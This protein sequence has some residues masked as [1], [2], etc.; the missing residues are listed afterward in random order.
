MRWFSRRMAARELLSGNHPARLPRR[1]A[2]RRRRGFEVLEPRLVLAVQPL[3]TEIMANNGSSLLDG[4]GADSDWIEV[5]NPTAATVNLAGWHLTDSAT[6]LDKWTFSSAPQSI[7]D[8]GEYLIVFASSKT[9]ETYI[10]PSGYLHT[11]FALA[12]EGE[13]LALTDAS[14]NI[15]HEFA[16]QFPPQ[17]FDVSY[18]LE[19]NTTTVTLI[20]DSSPVTSLVPTSGVLDA[21]SVGVA[22]AWTV[23]GFD[24][25]TWLASAAGPGVGFDFG[26]DTVI[27]NV[28]NGTVLPTGLVGS[29]LT[30]AD[31]NGTLEGTIFG[32]G[33]P[34]WPS[35]EEPPRALDNTSAT[36]W[37]AFDATGSSYGFRFAGGQQHAVN[38]YTITSAND[39]A[40]RDPYSWTLSG[41]ND[42]VNYTIVDTRS[43][44]TFSTRFQTRLYEFNNSTNYEYYRFDFKTKFGVT[45]LEVDRPSANAIQLA[46]IELFA[47]GPVDFDPLV[48]LDVEA[49]WTTQRTSAYQRVEFNVADP[50]SVVSLMLEM[51]YD[52]G[53]VAY[54]NGKRVA[55]VH[56]PPLPNFNS[57]ASAIRDNSIV[58]IPQSFDLAANIGE[59]V[60]GTN[61]LA[62]HVLNIDDASQDLLS[63]PRLVARQLI[64]DT[65]IPVY[66]TDP[67]P[68]AINNDGFAGIVDT[69]TLSAAHGFYNAPFQLVI[70]NPTP[71]AQLYYTT[72]GSQP[73]RT[74][75]TLYTGPINVSATTTVRAQAFL[76]TYL[77]STP[78]TA[79]YLFINDIV[80]QNHQAT[81]A[82]GFPALWGST[83]PDYGVD[84]DVIGNFNAAGQSTGGDLFGGIYA[85]TIKND[86]L[87]IPSLSLVMDI[88][89]MFGP[90]GI[91]TN[92]TLNGDAWERATSVELINP[93]GSPGFQIDAGVQIHGGAFRRHDLSRKHSL[94]LVFKGIYEGNTKLDFPWFG[95]GAA[96][97][98]DTIVLRMDSNDGYAWDATGPKAQYARDEW[99]RRTQ[100]DLGQ[101]SSHGA[102]VHLYI[103]GVYWGLYNPVERPDASFAASYYGG[104]K[105][106]WDAINTGEVLDGSIAA[107]NTLV[108]LSQ[109]VASASTE[110]ARTAA[111]MRVLGLNPNGT[112]NS[113]FETYLD[114][115]NY[116][117]YLM[118]NFYSG[119]NDWPQR[120]WF[121][122]RRKVPDSQGFVFHMWDAEWTLG[123]QSDINTNRLGVTVRA[124]HRTPV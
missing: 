106:E 124:A 7:L 98:F 63:R 60:A 37:L 117:D 39:A 41:S 121:A 59:L 109:A 36:K 8:P 51:Q 55:S 43:A 90:N 71:S 4:D 78:V 119:N 92:S 26:D 101:A 46:E 25:S 18:G 68:G 108:S 32:G 83:T 95:D 49:A 122:A 12:D 47:R 65:L 123:L 28:P 85:A 13:Y 66:M 19:P 77:P 81:L 5:H 89:D 93:D 50:A 24:D 105:E 9:V 56:A 102:R 30:D 116:A 3:I 103:N 82:K 110:A 54:L 88:D 70:T 33:P 61:V 27:N 73:S 58:L 87:A 67:S 80:R 44:Q 115:V 64:D 114:A 15:I 97:S 21:A 113:S 118:V 34:T 72:D 94:R 76:D 79:T 111:Y 91:Y 6:N 42:G 14:N 45:G 74:N 120:N 53:F 40:N 2:T 17:R 38:G 57:N 11:D 100:A 35:G 1:T 107:W 62:I 31:Q 84:P 99:G 96:T 20:G 10:D 48:N 104:E 86:L 29:D 23:P 69:P 75:G 22:P 16:P 52:D 112:D